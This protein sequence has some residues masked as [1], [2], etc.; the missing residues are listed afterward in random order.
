MTVTGTRVQWTNGAAREFEARVRGSSGGLMASASV[1]QIADRASGR[2]STIAGP[3]KRGTAASAQTG[4]VWRRGRA[5]PARRPDSV[6][7]E[8]R[9]TDREEAV[10]GRGVALYGGACG[11]W[12][13]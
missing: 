9:R 11:C 10:S 8:A 4:R 1:G 7:G 6:S 3:F 13:G 2:A 5:T 12:C